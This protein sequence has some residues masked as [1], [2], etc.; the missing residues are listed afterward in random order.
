MQ[1]S[2]RLF[3]D[4]AKVASG[5][6]N[7]L[8][9]LR[10]E[11]ETRVRERLERV[12]ADMDLVT[13]EEFDA[14]RAMATKARAEQEDLAGKL[15]RLEAE[16]AEVKAQQAA[17][18]GADDPTPAPQPAASRGRRRASPPARPPWARRSQETRAHSRARSTE[19]AACNTPPILAGFPA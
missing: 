5:A 15:A 3:D 7:T 9:G 14:V 13:R 8:G 6:M 4:F 18:A 11:I 2:N 1:T 10:E 17:P 16:L 12:A 19:R